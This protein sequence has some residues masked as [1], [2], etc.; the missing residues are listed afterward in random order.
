VLNAAAA[1]V[2][3]GSVNDLREGCDAAAH[4]IDSGA[5]RNVLAEFVSASNGT[6]R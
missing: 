5:A 4:S 2:V 3:A 1:L 6:G